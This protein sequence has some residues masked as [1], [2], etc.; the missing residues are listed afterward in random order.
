MVFGRIDRVC[1]KAVLFRDD[2]TKQDVFI[3]I[4]RIRKWGLHD[5]MYVTFAKN[6]KLDIEHGDEVWL[7]IPTWLAKRE[8]LA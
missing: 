3:P 7:D 8:W 6:I 1:K 2:R 4:S 5:G